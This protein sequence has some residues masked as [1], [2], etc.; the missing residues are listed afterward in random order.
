MIGLCDCNNFFVSCERVFDPGLNG[1]PVVVLSNN[2]G[3]V[4]ARSN[5]AKALGIKM[6][7]PLFKIR[8]LV[9]REGVK[10]MSSNYELY[11]DMS[12]RVFT[13][14]ASLAPD[15]EIYS[16]DEAF[17]D[18]DGISLDSLQQWGLEA[19]RIIRRHTGIPVS[20]G[21]SPTKTLAK[22]ASK[23]C[24]SYPALKGC[25]LMHRPE[26]VAKVLSHYPIEDV[27]GIG[28]RHRA[29]LEGHGITTGAQFVA[30]S[31]EWVRRQMSVTG[32]RTWLELRGER[33]IELEMAASS[34][35]SLTVSRSFAKEVTTLAELSA[36]VSAFAARAAHKLRQQGSVAGVLDVMAATN[37]FREDVPYY[38]LV[39]RHTFASATA[40]TLEINAAAIALT[41]RLFVEGYGYKKAGVMFSNISPAVA[42]QLSLFDDV[43]QRQT[44]DRLMR[45][46]DQINDKHQGAIS[47][48]SEA[49]SNVN[50]NRDHL[51]PRYTTHWDELLEVKV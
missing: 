35:K 39:L 3:C 43:E 47:L 20:I 13:T 23:L 28:R 9:Q 10:V 22:I 48:A 7:V 45:V 42:V 40:N 46:I 51:S 12:H 24:K 16:I 44:H 25:C 27:W 41:E 32:E 6:G 18:L 17:I 5:E 11:G 2:D 33:A 50:I 21:I 34:R 14:L 4:V 29:R 8:S 37:R 31:R 49:S 26:D 15:I 36:L 38:H 1:R 30:M 19:S